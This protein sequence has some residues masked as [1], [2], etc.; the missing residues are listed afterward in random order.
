MDGRHVCLRMTDHQDRQRALVSA[1]EERILVLDG[2]MGTML[3]RPTSAPT[4]SAA[5]TS[6]AA[7]RT[8]S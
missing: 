5:R 8:F 7:T 6:R 4:T 1:L 2:A 3:H